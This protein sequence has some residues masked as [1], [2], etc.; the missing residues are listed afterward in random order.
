MGVAMHNAIR[1]N[2]ATPAGVSKVL[3]PSDRLRY[4][5]GSLLLLVSASPAEANRVA[6]RT[7]ESQ[8]PLLSAEKVRGLL[9]GRVPDEELEARAN[10]LLGAAALKRLQAMTPEGHRA[11]VHVSLTDD[12]P[13]AQAFVIIEALPA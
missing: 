3:R 13:M 10:E 1:A 6:Q 12:P 5:P 4:A 9:T 7:L 8:A 2:L 11:V